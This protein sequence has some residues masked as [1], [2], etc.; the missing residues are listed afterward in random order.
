MTEA[1]PHAR[2][3]S[4]PGRRAAGPD[5]VV[6]VEPGADDGGVADAPGILKK[7]PDVVVT[8]ERSP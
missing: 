4:S 8:P 6:D 2:I 3:T 1:E 5:L 7:S